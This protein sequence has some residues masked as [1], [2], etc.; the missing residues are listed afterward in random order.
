MSLPKL[1]TALITPFDQSECVDY[2]SLNNLVN[3]HLKKNVSI[4]LFGTTG[5]CSTLTQQERKS[6]LEYVTNMINLYPEFKNNVMIGVGGNNTQETINNVEIA[7]TF[8]YSLFMVTTPYYNKP[9]QQ[10]MIAH[11]KK[12]ASTFKSDRFIMYNVPG[13]CVV[14]LLPESVKTI[15]DS[16]S[17]YIGIKEAS[18]NIGQM[19]KIKKLCPEDFYLYCGDDSLVIPAMSIGA[20]GLISVLSNAIPETMNNICLNP[21][22]PIIVSIYLQLFG[23]METLFVEPNPS[24]IKYLCMSMHKIYY[25]VVRLPLLTVQSMDLKS[26]L[27]EYSY[28]VKNY[29]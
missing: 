26:M 28:Q 17:N 13:R 15:V 25:D 19:V 2:I 21:N 8:G 11:F 27:D 6:I 1:Y 7:K 5:E 18:G 9:S 24:P 29:V 22:D 3:D 12:I 16:C 4:V 10:G 20:Y 23:L 14:N